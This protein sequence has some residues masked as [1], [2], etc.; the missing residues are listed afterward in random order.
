MSVGFNTS[1]APSGVPL[2]V[3][4]QR[5]TNHAISYMISTAGDT[6]SLSGDGLPSSRQLTCHWSPFTMPATISAAI[7]LVALAT[8]S[9]SIQNAQVHAYALAG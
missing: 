3:I 1:K 8:I 5:L 2:A 7:A 6:G 4:T 9:C